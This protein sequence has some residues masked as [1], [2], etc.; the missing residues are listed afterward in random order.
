MFASSTLTLIGEESMQ[1]TRHP[2]SAPTPPARDYVDRAVETVEGQERSTLATEELGPDQNN[3]FNEEVTV[4][5]ITTNNR[6]LR[7]TAT[8]NGG[9]PKVQLISS[10]LDN[11]SKLHV[12][13]WNKV[14]TAKLWARLFR[15][16]YQQNSLATVDKTREIIKNLVSVESDISLG[17]CFPHQE[18]VI[19]SNRFPLP[20]HMLISGLTEEQVNYLT[21]LEVVSTPD[22]T[23]FFKP[24]EDPRPS[25][26]ATL[27]GLTFMNSENAQRKVTDLIQKRLLGS[28][29]ITSHVLKNSSL[30]VSR[31]M[32]E[33]L[34]N[35]S[36]QYIEVKRST[37]RGGN[38]RGWNI[39]L[40]NSSLSD[41]DHAKLIRLMRACDYPTV[42]GCGIPL[43]GKDILLC[44]NCK[45]I[46]HDTPNCPFPHIP[47]WLGYKPKSTNKLSPYD[48]LTNSRNQD[49][50]SNRGR[51]G[52]RGNGGR[53][54]RFN[55]RRGG[56]GY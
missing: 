28:H 8:P 38:F 6:G 22:A 7:R 15:G 42:F 46:D 56:R 29:D 18:R 39:Y 26:V 36:V 1:T 17:V 5:N 12:E 11:V 55:S 20:Y 48:D 43:R 10:P 27:S 44:I 25:F 35:I 23:I 54:G 32:N 34:E 50:A 51:G 21:G 13:A 14:T 33:V 49:S 2:G 4:N 41:E 24:F 47:G 9:W 16:K 40:H 31:A 52:D 30:P 45:S 37:A 19:K 53:G 3:R